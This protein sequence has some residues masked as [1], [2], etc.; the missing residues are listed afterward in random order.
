MKKRI[1]EDYAP[2]RL[3]VWETDE[4]YTVSV[5]YTLY[6]RDK[7]KI[8]GSRSIL[9]FELDTCFLTEEVAKVVKKKL[10]RIKYFSINMYKS[11]HKLKYF[12]RLK[13][14]LI[15]IK[16]QISKFDN[17]LVL[18]FDEK[19]W[20][21]NTDWYFV[22]GLFG[23][24]SKHTASIV[25]FV[26]NPLSIRLDQKIPIDE[27]SVFTTDGHEITYR[28]GIKQS[29]IGFKFESDSDYPNPTLKEYLNSENWRKWHWNRPT[30]TENK[31]RKRQNEELAIVLNDILKKRQTL[32]SANPKDSSTQHDINPLD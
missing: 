12:L 9:G 23:S 10:Q 24:R 16:I 18:S 32:S 19:Y 20:I 13:R 11:L 14:S 31:S 7:E 22:K 6:T 25:E 2:D 26:P 8:E 4:S 1:Y 3:K 30:D 15:W 27:N 5:R 17:S 21:M 28:Y 29:K